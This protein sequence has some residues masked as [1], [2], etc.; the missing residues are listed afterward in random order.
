M[1]QAAHLVLVLANGSLDPIAVDILDTASDR[2]LGESQGT[3]R[4][5]GPMPKLSDSEAFTVEVV[6]ELLG[7]YQGLY[8][9]F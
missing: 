8:T 4:Q 1:H 7:T 5:R 3:S 6:G 9:F 2:R